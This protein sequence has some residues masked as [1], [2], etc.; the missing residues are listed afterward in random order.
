MTVQEVPFHI[1]SQ[2]I[3]ISQM[4]GLRHTQHKKVIV[5][6]KCGKCNAFLG[7]ATI[8]TPHPHD[9]SKYKQSDGGGID[10]RYPGKIWVT[11]YYCNLCGAHLDKISD[12]GIES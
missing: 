12:G 9:C 5:D 10:P 8:P 1:C 7:N 2:S 11:D 4:I 6:Y 3:V